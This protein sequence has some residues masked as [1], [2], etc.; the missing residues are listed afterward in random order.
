MDLWALNLRH[1]RAAA[2]ITRL[3]SINAAAQAVNLTQPAI[4]QA[5]GNL[6]M[7]LG[8]PLFERRHNG[9]EPLKA[10]Q[11]LA[12]RIDAAI[13]N[14]GSARVTMT[15][16]RALIAVG[17]AGSY[18]Q[19]GKAT[20]LAQ[21]SLHRAVNDLAL[22]LR[23]T[24]IERR[25]KGIG[26]TESGWRTLRGFRLARA[27]LNA[28][29]SEIEGLKGKETGRLSIGAMPV[30]RARLL[31]AAVTTFHALHPEVRINILEGSWNE[32]V[33]PLR[34]GDIDLMVGALREP[35]HDLAQ[36]ALFEDRPSIF[37]RQ[38][39]PALQANPNI[40]DLAA[41]PWTVPS[42]GTPL[43]A[44][45]QAMFE[46]AGVSIPTVPIECGSVMMIR[47]IL[48]GSNFLT[49]L[50]P[51]QIAVE[52]EAGWLAPICKAPSG[53]MRTIGIITRAGW[54]P[55]AK[56]QEF[57]NIITGTKNI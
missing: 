35:I 38:G 46:H 51:D 28:A 17:D 32:L 30:S 21:P 33:E 49:L 16:L 19:A 20:G 23:R 9:M 45:W 47:Q 13:A 40:A 8:L 15:Q 36:T 53:V 18:L 7:Q 50:S 57:L 22:A 29:L 34:D 11:L 31:P 26:L 56:Q 39:H 14:I 6:E 1:L 44:Q 5:I 54:R 37:A 24:L 10:M 12:P 52:L 48:I 2:V 41:Y 25:G 4:T 55:T 27:E 3:G 42:E 43:R